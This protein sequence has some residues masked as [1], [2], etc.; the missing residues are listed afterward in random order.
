MSKPS[1]RPGDR[2]AGAQQ[3]RVGRDAGDEAAALADGVHGAAGR[4]PA[5]LRHRGG[6]RVRLQAVGGGDVGARRCGR[7][8]RGRAGGR[9]GRGSTGCAAGSGRTPRP[10]CRPRR[11]GWRPPPRTPRS[12]RCRRRLIGTPPAA[13]RRPTRRRGPR[14]LRPAG[15]APRRTAATR[16]CRPA[17]SRSA[18][19]AP[20]A[21]RRRRCR[22]RRRWRCPCRR[23]RR[24]PARPHPPSR[25]RRRGRGSPGGPWRSRTTAAG[26]GRRMPGSAS[27]WAISVVTAAEDACQAFSN[28]APE[29]RAMR[30]RLSFDFASKPA[31]RARAVDRVSA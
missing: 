31:I 4:H 6:R 17:G 20:T 12:E 25:R 10:S 29:P 2:V 11:P 28:A 27:S 3:Q 21:A 15:P 5:G 18:R 7:G 13:S 8:R 16:R 1:M 14:P 9:R 22:R 19:S 26:R 30:V 23:P 24:W